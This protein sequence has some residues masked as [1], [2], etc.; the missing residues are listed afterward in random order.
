MNEG[1]RERAR[2]VRA[3]LSSPETGFLLVAGASPERRDEALRFQA[4]LGER[5]L[6]RDGVVVNRVQ[7]E[8]PASCGGRARRA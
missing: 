6:Q 5:G 1:F 2:A 3:L 7:E 4:V 8:P